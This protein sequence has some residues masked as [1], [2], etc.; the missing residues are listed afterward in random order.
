MQR[1]DTNTQKIDLNQAQTETIQRSASEQAS[2][3]RINAMARR[4]AYRGLA[5]QHKREQTYS[6][7]PR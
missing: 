6:V 5:R 3:D 1:M 7:F 2:R 4:M